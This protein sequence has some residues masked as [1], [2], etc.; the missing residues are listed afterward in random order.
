MLTNPCLPELF[1]ETY[2]AWAGALALLAALTTHMIQFLASRAIHSQLG[3][4][5]QQVD[6]V[7]ES[8]AGPQ[9]LPNTAP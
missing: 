6:K 2:T 1:T 3:S 8:I 4:G 7:A 9:E 5:H